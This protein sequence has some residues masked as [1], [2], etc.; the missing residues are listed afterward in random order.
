MHGIERTAARELGRS[1]QPARCV[2]L[3]IAISSRQRSVIQNVMHWTDPL[4]QELINQ[5]G[6][7]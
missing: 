7:C 5:C 1:F 6:S 3:V 2:V 4:I